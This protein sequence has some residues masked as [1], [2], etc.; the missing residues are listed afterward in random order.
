[1]VN[2]TADH[3]SG[4]TCTLSN[5]GKRFSSVASL[6][7]DSTSCHWRKFCCSHVRGDVVINFGTFSCAVDFGVNLF[8]DCIGFLKIGLTCLQVFNVAVVFVELGHIVRVPGLFCTTWCY[9]PLRQRAANGAQDGDSKKLCHN[10]FIF[11]GLTAF[12]V[13]LIKNSVIYDFELTVYS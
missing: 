11:I 7:I 8:D 2:G 5:C 6:R 3:G 1:M 4:S 9:K 10:D 12:C 13:S